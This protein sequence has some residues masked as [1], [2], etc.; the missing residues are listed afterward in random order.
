MTGGIIWEV[1]ELYVDWLT[2]YHYNDAIG[3]YLLYRIGGLIGIVFGRWT[4]DKGA[5]QLPERGGARPGPD[6]GGTPLSTVD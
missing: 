1:V 3:D 4:L 6:G 2:V 5:C